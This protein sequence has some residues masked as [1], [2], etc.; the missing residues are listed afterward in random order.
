MAGQSILHERIRLQFRHDVHHAQAISTSGRRR[1]SIT[2]RSP[3]SCAADP[4]R[5][6]RC[7]DRRLRPAAGARRGAGRRIHDHDRRPRRP[8]AARRSRNT[9]KSIVEP[10][11]QQPEL[12]PSSGMRATRRCSGPTSPRSYLD[13]D[14]TACMLKGVDLQDAFVDAA[15]LSRLAVRQRLQSLRPNLA[16]DRPVRSEVPRP[17][18]R[19]QPA[20]GAEQPAERWCPWARWPR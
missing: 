17:E 9:P 15:G 13:V 16:G 1:T 4:P 12:T 18:R 14:R 19:H 2:K 6:H 10:A 5:G 7:R 11:N 20:A 8:G 3:T